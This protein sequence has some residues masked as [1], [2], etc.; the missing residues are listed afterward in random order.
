MCNLS[1][2]VEE[3]GIEKGLRKGLKEGR[4]SERQEI[5][6]QMLR[7]GMP[8]EKIIQYTQIPVET[9]QQWTQN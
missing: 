5:A 2:L 8:Y 9:L 6:L 3:R 1:D 7:D 4:D